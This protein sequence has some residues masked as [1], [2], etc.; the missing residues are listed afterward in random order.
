MLV[1]LLIWLMAWWLAASICC[2]GVKLPTWFRI[3]VWI[4]TLALSLALFRTPWWF[5]RW[6][7]GLIVAFSCFW[8]KILT[9]WKIAWCC[10]C[11]IWIGMLIFEFF[12]ERE[13]LEDYAVKVN[14][15]EKN[16]QDIL[17]KYTER[18][19]NMSRIITLEKDIVWYAKQMQNTDCAYNETCND[20]YLWNSLSDKL[21]NAFDEKDRIW[22]KSKAAISKEKQVKLEKDVWLLKLLWMDNSSELGGSLASYSSSISSTKSS[23]NSKIE[24]ITTL[25]ADCDYPPILKCNTLLRND[26]EKEY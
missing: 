20:A 10:C 22:S 9:G 8:A 1:T 2:C 14:Q 26:L 16:R 7:G 15:E 19:N 18:D 6:I 21:D 24:Q 12:N 13:A 4:L 5:F 23:I 25:E 17:S 3:L 11:I